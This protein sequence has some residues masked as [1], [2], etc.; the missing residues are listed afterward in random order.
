MIAAIV[1]AAGRSR[2]MGTQKVLLPFGGGTVI[3]HIADEVLRS[4]LDRLV[5]VAGQDAAAIAQAL[6][7]RPVGVVANPDPEGDM[8]SSVR[9]GLLALPPDAEGVLLALG[10][11]PAITAV[12]VD[13]LVGALRE[14][15]SG[16]VVP[17]YGGRRG[18]PL[19]FSGVYRAE[20]LSR[21]DDVGLRGL[22]QAHPKD[23]REV[24]VADAWVLADMD[25]P[26]DYQRELERLKRRS[27]RG[28]SCQRA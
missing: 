15:G 14:S 16:I 20:L 27:G 2:R 25:V 4:R 1:L 23:V 28:P 6:A 3:S 21:H 18:H 10:D 5:V 24:P 7:D 19:L 12:L 9:C 26:A 8:L 11:Q 17:A 13:R 22:L